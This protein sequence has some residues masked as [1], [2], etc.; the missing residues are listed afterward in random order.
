L[1][2]GGPI[3]NLPIHNVEFVK[4]LMTV[5][6]E[7]KEVKTKT[8]KRITAILTGI[9]DEEPLQDQPLSFDLN[10]IASSLKS[11]NP[12]KAQ[13]MYAM[14]QLGYKAVQTYYSS[15]L[16]KTNAPPHVLY[17]IFKVFKTQT[18]KNDK[19]KILANL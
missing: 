8:A 6:R 16:W 18:Y 12:G 10:F 11:M 15:K 4:R 1:T 9:I 7:Q 2:I 5:T 17:D 13:F 19:D 3:W 14:N